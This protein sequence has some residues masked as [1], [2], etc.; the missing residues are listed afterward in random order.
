MSSFHNNSKRPALRRIR[1]PLGQDATDFPEKMALFPPSGTGARRRRLNSLAKRLVVVFPLHH[2]VLGHD[3]LH[4]GLERGFLSSINKNIEN[5]NATATTSSA[6]VSDLNDNILGNPRIQDVSSRNPARA[7]L[8][9]RPEDKAG[10]HHEHDEEDV[11]ETRG[12]VDGD[13]GV[14]G[15]ANKGAG[16]RGAWGRAIE[17]IQA[18]QAV[19]AWLEQNQEENTRFLTMWKTFHEKV[20]WMYADAAAISEGKGDEMFPPG[21]WKGDLGFARTVM[22]RAGMVATALATK[23]PVRW[24]DFMSVD[25][26]VSDVLAKNGNEERP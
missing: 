1:K 15:A 4:R 3:N 19:K 14:A 23:N 8:Q 11:E 22:N 21:Y 5:G 2:H 13:V 26:L 25:E 24:S 16:G 18:G 7:F 17:R 6:L 10:D 12:G 20:R 9:M